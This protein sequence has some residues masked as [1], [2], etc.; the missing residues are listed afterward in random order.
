MMRIMKIR[1]KSSVMLGFYYHRTDFVKY[2]QTCT[3][4]RQ[5]FSVTCLCIL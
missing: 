4:E 5:R 1:K 2:G 3:T